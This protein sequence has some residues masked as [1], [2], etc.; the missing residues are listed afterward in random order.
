MR[1]QTQIHTRKH[2]CTHRQTHRE[3][4]TCTHKHIHRHTNTQTYIQTHTEVHKHTHIDAHMSTQMHKDKMRSYA[5]LSVKSLVHGQAHT[6]PSH[7]SSHTFPHSRSTTAV[8]ATRHPVPKA[9]YQLGSTQHPP[10]CEADTI[11]GPSCSDSR[12]SP[13]SHLE[14][15][16]T[17]TQCSPQ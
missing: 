9:P 6:Q 12:L 1:T 3:T 4:H 7:L 14:L 5:A 15:P 16:G 10:Q 11:L 2:T 13:A 17:Q 8:S